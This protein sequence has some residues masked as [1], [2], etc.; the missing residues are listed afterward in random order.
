MASPTSG[1]VAGATESNITNLNAPV[2]ALSDLPGGNTASFT[3]NITAGCP[4]VQAINDGQT[5][6]N[7]IVATY[8]GGSKQTISN[9]YPV[10]TGFLDIGTITPPTVN[11]QKGDVVM[12]MITMKNTRQGPIQ[13]LSFSDQHFPG[14]SIQLVGGINQVNVP[15]LFTA[16]IPAAFLPQWATE[17]ICSNSTKKLP[18]W[19]K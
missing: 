9:L 11:A 3:L 5:F 19:K 17:M 10:E 13:S 2:F 14:I 1:W 6:S 18:W 12:R 15:T 7:T 4:V 8:A 16:D